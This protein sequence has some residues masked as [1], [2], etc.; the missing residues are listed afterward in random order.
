MGFLDRLLRGRRT[1]LDGAS[2]PAT[3]PEAVARWKYLLLTAPPEALAEAHAE[4]LGHLD[5]STRSDLLHRIRAALGDLEPG[6][7]VPAEERLLLRAAA[8]TERRSPGFLERALSARTPRTSISA[9]AEVV[10]ATSAAAPFLRDFAA[11]LDARTLA[12]VQEIPDAPADAAHDGH[13]GH[14]DVS[15]GSED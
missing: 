4:A 11:D 15:D 12:E 8:R 6:A 13:D 5:R 3:G 2:T 7:V 10:V 14:D 1:S 9:L